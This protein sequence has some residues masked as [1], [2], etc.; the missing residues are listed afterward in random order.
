MGSIPNLSIVRGELRPLI[1]PSEET[2]SRVLE[3]ECSK[4]RQKIALMF[5]SERR[6]FGELDA[7]ANRLARAMLRHASARANSDGDFIVAVNLEPGLELVTTLLAVW[8]LGAAY[9]PLDSC[10]PSGRVT[11]ILGEAQPVLVIADKARDC[12]EPTPTVLYSELS[13]QA[14]ELSSDAVPDSC[15]LSINGPAIILYTSGSTGVPKGVRLPHK[16]ILN[17][18]RWQWQTFPYAPEESVCC[19]KTALTFVDSVSELWGPLLSGRSVLVVPREVTRDPERLVALLDHHKVERLVL[20]PSL[21]RSILMVLQPGELSSL[22]T[23]VCSGEPLSTQLARDFFIHFGDGQ[24]ILCNFYG[25]TE[26]MG[27]VTYHVLRSAAELKELSK[28]PIGRAVD[29][30]SIY[31]LD[32]HC[33]PVV[34][35]E[36]GE[37]Y[38]SGLNLALGYVRGRDPERWVP[39]PITV[40]PDHSRMY[41][42]GDF[43]RVEKGVLI[44]EGRT[45]SQ[46]K[47]RGHRV[48]LAEVEKAV[49]SISGVEKCV[50]LCYK[51]GELEQAL[52][53]Y[54]TG[55]T[56][57]HVQDQMSKVLADYM[58]PQV[59]AIDSIPL[60]VNGKTDRQ[61]LLRRYEQGA[62]LDYTDVPQNHMEAAQ[63]LFETV[64]QVLGAGARDK[65]SLT[66]NFYHLG[67]NSLNSVFTVTK[68]RQR[69][70]KISVAQFVSAQ[71]LKEILEHMQNGNEPS[72][73]EQQYKAHMLSDEYKED[74]TL[75]IT[76]SFYEKADLEQWLKPDV[77]R[78]DYKEL[79]DA[80]WGPL[81][82][83]NLSFI[84]KDS[85]GTPVGVALNFDVHDEPEVKITSKLEVVFEFL[86]HLEGPLR[87]NKLPAGKGKVLHSFM[88]ATHPDLS[89]QNNVEVIHS[90][91]N[92]VLNL[93]KRRGFTGIFA[94]NTNPLTQQ[95]GTDIYGYEPLIDYQVNQ[96]V[97]PNGTQPFKDA[98]DDQRAVC[99][100]RTV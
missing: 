87:D 54:V 50:V 52:V 92:E 48:D 64:A 9:L 14:T 77:Y 11:H 58:R 30:T 78:P 56:S 18:L 17:R 90:M 76:E 22:R 26:I 80:L 55:T 28:V 99:A 12:Y 86:E 65:V 53:A 72:E 73:N 84:V 93:A 27:D 97:A 25:S 44:Y 69:G 91:E 8:K 61:A 3:L 81:I 79:T 21:L 94:T 34:S 46:V 85:K 37:L 47:I 2:L 51:P 15:L 39:N 66:A 20:V 59:I 24:Q 31:L 42:T 23:W 40:D 63:A 75:M 38:V 6:T 67:G 41:R 13:R 4:S 98:P 70:Y 29:N 10:F 1:T 88:M 45:D 19:F 71:N 96:Y 57:A 32:N 68:L 100:W 43:A 82:E 89:Y 95:L 7:S 16:A 83:K 35:G 33:R 49:S 60:L 62:E 74:V 36:T 5:Q